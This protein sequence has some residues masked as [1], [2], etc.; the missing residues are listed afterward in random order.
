MSDSDDID[1]ELRFLNGRIE[2]ETPKCRRRNFQSVLVPEPGRCRPATWRRFFRR[3]ELAAALVGAM[4]LAGFVA[5]Q[6]F[7]RLFN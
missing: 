5:Y 4:A 1:R 2:R 7:D 3:V 6:L